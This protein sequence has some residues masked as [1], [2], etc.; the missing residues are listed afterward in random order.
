MTKKIK[1]SILSVIIFL[2]SL[3][4][5]LGVVVR[6][7]YAESMKL[8]SANIIKTEYAQNTYFEMPIYEFSLSGQ[9]ETATGI[10]YSPS[11]KAYDASKVKLNE[12]GN[13]KVVYT[14]F[15][16][17][18]YEI[19][20]TVYKPTYEVT[21]SDGY[22]IPGK[23]ETYFGRSGEG[24]IVNIPNGSEFKY[25]EVIDISKLTKLDD[26]IEFGVFPTTPGTSDIS[27]V[28]VTLTDIY[29]S[30]KFV[31]FRIVNPN[32]NDKDAYPAAACVQATHSD[33]MVYM[34]KASVSATG[35]PV[36][37]GNNAFY[38][39][40]TLFSFDGILNANKDA[41]TKL[42]FDYSSQICHTN[43]GMW[44]G[45]ATE[46][47]PGSYIIDVSKTNFGD[48]KLA[49]TK[50]FF[51]QPFSGFTTG[52]VYLS[53]S[54]GDY[55]SSSANFFIKNI[56]GANFN[57]EKSYDKYNPYISID[58]LG[59]NSQNLPK[60][61][62]N[63]EYTL[64]GYN[65]SDNEL[66]DVRTI[67]KVYSVMEGS[68]ISRYTV[69]NGKFIPDHVGTYEIVYSATDGYGNTAE[70]SVFIEAV[71]DIALPVINLPS[72][73]N[74]DRFVEEII[75]VPTVTAQSFSGN[76]KLTAKVFY[77]GNEVG[78][79]NDCFKL[80]K[81][82]TYKIE[83]TATDYIGQKTVETLNIYATINP[84]PV[85]AEDIVL[86]VGF[87][88]G[89]TYILDNLKAISYNTGVK[90]LVSPTITVIDGA[91]EHE[92]DNYTYTVNGAGVDNVTVKY[93]YTSSTGSTEKIFTV[94]VISP[95]T[96]PNDYVKYFL[97]N[98]NVSAFINNDKMLQLNY[99]GEGTATFIKSIPVGEFVSQ[100][101]VFTTEDVNY[102]F[103][104][105][106]DIT[107]TDVTD[108][109]K[110]IV[111]SIIKNGDNAA[112]ISVNNGK[113]YDYKASF[114]GGVPFTLS[115]NNS[116][117]NIVNGST[118]IPVETFKDGSPF[119]PFK[120]NKAY[121]SFSCTGATDFRIIID[122]IAG[123]GFNEWAD[124]DYLGP[125]IYINGTMSS[126][127]DINSQIKTNTALSV[128]VLQENCTTSISLTSP[129][130][131]K[132][133]VSKDAS[134]SYDVTLDEYGTYK[135]EYR[136]VDASG[137]VNSKAITL[138]VDER[139]APELNL[140]LGDFKCDVNVEIDLPI[141]TFSDNI[142]PVEKMGCY[143][144][145]FDPEGREYLIPVTVTEN[146]FTAKF[147][148][149]QVGVWKLKYLVF[150]ESYNINI[151]ELTVY[152]GEFAEEVEQ[153]RNIELI[154]DSA[155]EY[156]ILIPHNSSK[157]E[158]IGAE[159]LQKVLYT[160]T[161]CNF[162]IIEDDSPAVKITDKFISFGVTNMY[163]ESG[164]DLDTSDLGDGYY[165][166]E[167]DGNFYI[168]GGTK[169]KD[170]LYASQDFLKE[171][172]N[173]EAYHLREVTFDYKAT[174]YM[175]SLDIFIEATFDRRS[176]F[177]HEI[178]NST[179][180]STYQD[181][182]R[183]DDVNWTKEGGGHTIFVFLK[184]SE[185]Y[186]DH[187]KW[188]TG[189]SGSDQICW[190][191]PDMVEEMTKKVIESVKATKKATN[192]MI[193]QNDG[194]NWCS[195]PDCTASYN[196]YGVNSA[197]LIKGLNKIAKAVKAYLDANEPGREVIVTTFA[198]TSTAEPPVEIDANGNYVAIDDSVICEPN[199]G[200][201]IAPYDA[202]YSRPFDHEMNEA[203]E[204][205]FR[206][207]AAVCQNIN[208][209]NY[210][211]NFNYLQIPF[212]NWNTIKDNYVFLKECNVSQVME[213]AFGKQNGFMDLRIWLMS[214]F[215]YNLDQNMADLI[216]DYFRDYY[217]DGGIWM[218]KFF[219]ETRQWYNV[220]EDKYSVIN[221]T[222][223]ARYGSVTDSFPLA[224]IERWEG[225]IEKA[226]E[227][228]EYIKA[229]D[230]EYYNEIY[231]RIEKE[232]ILFDYI[233]LFNY[234]TSYTEQELY[235]MRLEF[236]RKCEKN[237]IRYM[238]EGGDLATVYA[239]W[240]I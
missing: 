8:E 137:N 73:F 216:D 193:G 118:M 47:Y 44:Y 209:W 139:I 63:S 40:Y 48:C 64:F 114:S 112:R 149:D 185:Y 15:T 109:S 227:E 78:V 223:Y 81:N 105:S 231:A 147:T 210:N 19:P 16:N 68:R 120:D 96:L 236:K 76:A 95:A 46:T 29:D 9:I 55:S 54:A 239:G 233:R 171:A 203:F 13:W 153:E 190:S 211:T 235:E 32:L 218:Q 72:S 11:Q 115:F 23:N 102:N 87:I 26:I 10:L 84:N 129:S 66:S 125:K 213:Q 143:L 121:V 89:S 181:L 200:V 126:H 82:G 178:S 221:G 20:F 42:S 175:P 22:A 225:Y 36:I 107:F 62:V 99:T 14:A 6:T 116:L 94:P 67:K 131:K 59:E 152:V 43:T 108:A 160:A 161:G 217:K 127:Y 2:A 164:L 61:K 70:K 97:T 206:G 50:E 83:Y 134:I 187:P 144:S 60:A 174:V 155:T 37:Y 204:A 124:G 71:E 88:N 117:K 90:T 132:I 226:Y 194:R 140:D 199:V 195:C 133:L 168:I 138:T 92:I 86:P 189:T 188:Y 31:Q 182:I 141:A 101:T 170:Y 179:S 228:I 18:T 136:G 25:N 51:E 202:D 207:W 104:T 21:S 75:S 184:T 201:R 205:S 154:K 79:T 176:F 103:A 183:Y 196:Q 156:Y 145:Y 212:C 237:D 123:Q 142:T 53:I 130:G 135:M 158:S 191:Q 3:C 197:V 34:G 91:G 28:Y 192:V 232:T 57:R 163:T 173:Y 146:T 222:C 38:G 186:E 224:V 77:A 85:V 113:E 128:D 5:V 151:K 220:I 198:Y 56:Y 80:E 180:P 93:L 234:K 122:E 45:S 167:K 58:Y 240:G 33:S 162:E 65:T 166:K 150:D 214:E 169:L 98:G 69:K 215:M 159:N 165:I 41:L 49:G 1:F 110:F 7:G 52:E 17:Q 35:E 4:F 24:L 238:Q 219:D 106:F 30:S 111:V 39:V 172:I 229:I 230:E 148:F 74:S 157:G 27:K 12:T 119:V 177:N 208:V 100:Y